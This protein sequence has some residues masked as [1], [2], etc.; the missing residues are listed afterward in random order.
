MI[1]LMLALARLTHGPLMQPFTECK[2]VN[3]TPLIRSN[4]TAINWKCVVM[5]KQRKK[6]SVLTGGKGRCKER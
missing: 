3:D 1:T 4:I 5:K 6:I 2:M